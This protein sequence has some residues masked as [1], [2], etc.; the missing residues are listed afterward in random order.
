[1]WD[2]IQKD[3]PIRQAAKQ[4]EPQIASGG[5]RI[6]GN[7][8]GARLSTSWTLG[9]TFACWQSSPVFSGAEVVDGGVTATSSTV[10]PACG[11]SG[12]Y[13]LPDRA[14]GGRQSLDALTEIPAELNRL[15]HRLL[16][17]S[18]LQPER[19]D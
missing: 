15:E 19:R 2:M 9:K 16:L 4:V 12:G 14:G 17:W 7:L 18:R 6:G 8:H 13:R 1:M 3:R 11:M 10:L 5:W